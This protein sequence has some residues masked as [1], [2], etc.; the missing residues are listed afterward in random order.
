[1][2]REQA[3]RIGREI[4]RMIQQEI[5]WSHSRNGMCWGPTGSSSA[6]PTDTTAAPSTRD[7]GERNGGSGRGHASEHFPNIVA[8]HTT[9]QVVGQGPAAQLNPSHTF[10]HEPIVLRLWLCGRQNAGVFLLLLRTTHEP[11]ILRLFLDAP[12]G[13]KNLLPCLH[14][15]DIEHQ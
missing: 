4:Q 11:L 8:D 12:M 10:L 7:H 14:S 13:L 5:R 1:M 15:F 2:T 9:S 3:E 6:N